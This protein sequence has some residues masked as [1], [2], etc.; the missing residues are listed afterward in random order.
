MNK[1]LTQEE[2]EKVF[3]WTGRGDIGISSNTILYA[4]GGV[5]V[6][7]HSMD[8]PYDYS[9]LKR[10]M[11]LLE[12]VPSFKNK[13]HIVAEKCPKWKPIV[14]EWETIEKEFKE[15]NTKTMQS[16][17]D[18][19]MLCDGWVKSRMGWSKGNKT[20]LTGVLR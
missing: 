3:N 20:F 9:D 13:L 8:I 18:E 5:S 12:C 14:R 2:M 7:G 11:D 4:I 10:C 16:L 17:H 19:C 6:Y 1:N 15:G